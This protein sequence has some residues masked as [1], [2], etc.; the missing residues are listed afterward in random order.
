MSTR[1]DVLDLE[2]SGWIALS[3]SP[4]AATHFFAEVLADRALMLL[5]GGLVIDDRTRALESMSG[6]PWSSFDSMTVVPFVPR[7][8]STESPE[9][10]SV[11]LEKAVTVA[12]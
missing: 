8:S 4:E 10:T 3:T 1:D 9:P 12:A 2:R 11:A 7:R 6:A 5:P